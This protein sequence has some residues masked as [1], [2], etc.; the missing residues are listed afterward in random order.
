MSDNTLSKNLADV[1]E[2]K[3]IVS[4]NSRGGSSNGLAG[5]LVF[6][7]VLVAVLGIASLIAFNKFRSA[8][9]SE[10]D[11]ISKVENK[12]AAVGNLRK[13]DTDAPPLPTG[14]KAKDPATVQAQ[15]TCADN[16]LGQA[17]LDQEGKPLLGATGQPMR[18]CQ[19]GVVLTPAAPLKVGDKVPPVTPPGGANNPSQQGQ[20][21]GQGTL[22]PSRYAGDV[23][24]PAVSGSG[25]GGGQQPIDPNNPYIKAL[26]GGNQTGSLPITTPVSNALNFGAG[27]GS[28]GAPPQGGSATP[29]NQQGAIGGLLQ[30]S[31][32][33][34]VSAS[35]IGDRNMILPQG[36]S[37]DCNLSTRVISEVSG[38]ATCVF[39]SNV[40]SDNGRVLLAERGSEAT[41]QYVAA[42]AQGQRRLFLLWTRIKTPKGVIVN[43][44][45]PVADSL[46]TSGLDGYVDN[47]WW[48]R[49]GAA[50]LL[51]FVQDAIG[52][53]TAKATGGNGGAQGVAVFQNSTQTGNTIA[54]K[55]LESTINIKPTLFKNQGDRATIFVARDV[56]FGGVYALRAN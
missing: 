46:G 9:K 31:P 32:T 10:P 8:K 6:I 12:P 52:Y 17:L 43:I 53:E 47:R 50:F 44:N 42:T 14:V 23:I 11:Q 29:G 19:N 49:I 20:Q 27:G 21:A 38:L 37:I 51:S 25:F 35:L 54:Q 55:V 3:G 34:A 39:S 18:V 30:G 41:G 1:P 7:F 45:S 56:D 28:N 4:V 24:V 26:L 22:P 13:F 2:P 36:R 33:P 5:K 40:F 16:S 48:E 15:A